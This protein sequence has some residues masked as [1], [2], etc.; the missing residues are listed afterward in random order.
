[1]S[2]KTIIYGMPSCDTT[3]KG[4]KFLE[5]NGINFEFHNYKKSGVTREIIENLFSI[6]DKKEVVTPQGLIFKKLDK[7]V[8]EKIM[9]DNDFAI[10]KLIENP[11]M[12]KRPIVVRGAIAI[13]GFKE[14][15]WNSLI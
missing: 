5:E 3:A 4:I 10:E 11:F 15:L 13:S 9:N 2:N 12:I 8:Q 1:M 6:L 7:E 14:A